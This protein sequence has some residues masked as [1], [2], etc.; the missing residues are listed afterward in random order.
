MQPFIRGL[1][2]KAEEGTYIPKQAVEILRAKADLPEERL[3]LIEN[4][5]VALPENTTETSAPKD[6]ESNTENVVKGSTTFKDVL[7]RGLK[8][9]QIERVLGTQLPDVNEKIGDFCNSKGIEFGPVKEELQSLLNAERS[10]ALHKRNVKI[11]TLKSAQIRPI[12]LNIM[13][14]HQKLLIIG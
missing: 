10:V 2:F 11:S 1:P 9:E 4:R 12:S 14:Y 3:L 5:S 7:D 13:A 8:R 6:K